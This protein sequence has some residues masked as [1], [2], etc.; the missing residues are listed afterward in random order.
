MRG[1]SLTLALLLL[2]ASSGPALAATNTQ[3]TRNEEASYIGG[4]PPLIHHPALT[5]P[6]STWPC[7]APEQNIAGACFDLEP[8]DDTADITIHDDTNAHVE[9]RAVFIHDNQGTIGSP[10]WFCTPLSNLVLLTPA[11]DMGAVQLAITLTSPGYSV[12]AC[13]SPASFGTTGTVH[14]V[15]HKDAG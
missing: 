6:P 13:D 5:P 12:G 1:K 9:A 14:A 8:D 4:L 7:T 15:F 2:L 3:E 11:N 10:V